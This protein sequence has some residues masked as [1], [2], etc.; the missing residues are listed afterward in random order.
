[1][2]NAIPTYYTDAAA[3]VDRITEVPNADFSTGANLAA[4]NACGIGINIDGGEVVG[5]PAQFT[6][7][8]QAEAARTPQTSQILGEDATAIK[9]GAPSS[10]GDG[11]VPI[12]SDA[13]LAT[14][15]AGWI[16]SP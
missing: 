8:D 11:A 13:T 3:I 14:L 6:L 4:S 2:S 5:T 7:L 15:E 9:A 16:A 10:S 1:M 12:S